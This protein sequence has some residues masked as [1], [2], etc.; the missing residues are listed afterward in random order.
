MSDGIR[1]SWMYSRDEYWKNKHSDAICEIKKL[2]RKIKRL[3]NKLKKV[4]KK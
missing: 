3:E 1:D 4:K 2:E